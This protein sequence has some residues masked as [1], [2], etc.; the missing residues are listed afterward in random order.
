MIGQMSAAVLFGFTID[1]AMY[2]TNGLSPDDLTF[3]LL[4]ALLG[5]VVVGFGVS[6]LV[7]ARLIVLPVEGQS[8]P[9]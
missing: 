6:A 7:F 2:A 5:S 1:L 8:L 9:S 4:Q 3:R